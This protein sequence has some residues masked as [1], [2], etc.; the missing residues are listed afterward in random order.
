[1]PGKQSP[2]CHQVPTSFYLSLDI[3]GKTL[4][5]WGG[6]HSAQLHPS[7]LCCPNP[8][9]SL[10]WHGTQACNACVLILHGCL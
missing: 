5:R 10:P 9:S 8:V 4:L 6:L 3:T 7:A 1:M 2:G